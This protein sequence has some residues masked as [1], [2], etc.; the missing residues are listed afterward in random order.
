MS[1]SGKFVRSF[2]LGLC[3]TDCPFLFSHSEEGAKLLGHQSESE[4][5][6]EVLFHTS[7]TQATPPSQPPQAQNDDPPPSYTAPQALQ[8]QPATITPT[9]FTD[10]QRPQAMPT[11]VPVPT[12]EAPPDYFT[13]EAKSV[14][15]AGK[16]GLAVQIQI[17]GRLVPGTVMEDVS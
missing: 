16:P 11:A 1:R 14:P 13:H 17:D 7:A 9:P 10:Y 8:Q 12:D 5:E 3:L 15:R 4:E 2:V 6:E